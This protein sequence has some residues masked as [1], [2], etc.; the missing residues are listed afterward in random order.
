MYISPCG[1]CPLRGVGLEFHQSFLWRKVVQQLLDALP[2][3]WV[4]VTKDGQIVLVDE[5]SDFWRNHP[6]Y[7]VL[8]P[9]ASPQVEHHIG[10]LSLDD[11]EW[12]QWHLSRLAFNM[13]LF[14]NW[15]LQENRN[16][17]TYWMLFMAE[18][19]QIFKIALSSW[20]LGPSLTVYTRVSYFRIKKTRVLTT[21]T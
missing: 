13:K 14:L 18:N 1:T 3:G 12:L 15:I 21:F 6:G 7:T 9:A 5:G 2:S 10:Q 16:W 8:D 20:A 19:S 4:R 17:N 11:N